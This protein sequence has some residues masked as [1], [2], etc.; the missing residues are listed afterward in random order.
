MIVQA[1]DAMGKL[2]VFGVGTMLAKK[3]EPVAVF[4]KVKDTAKGAF[5][6]TTSV[7][8]NNDEA[9]QKYTY[10]NIPCAV[11]GKQYNKKIFAML[12]TLNAHDIVFFAGK[13]YNHTAIDSKSGEQIDFSEVRIE[14]LI[15]L[16]RL[17][18]L[19]LGDSKVRKL[20]NDYDQEKAVTGATNKAKR[21]KKYKF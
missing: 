8:R 20:K 13:Y 9:K 11:Y 12:E 7:Q 6:I 14:M 2:N 17:M 16:E 5:T 15:P 19:L 21:E 4:S 10:Q 3:G 18:D 1:R